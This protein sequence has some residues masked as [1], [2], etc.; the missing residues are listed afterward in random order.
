VVSS[1]PARASSSAGALPWGS[2][3]RPARCPNAPLTTRKSGQAW[4]KSIR[5]NRAK[6]S[7][8]GGGRGVTE[9]SSLEEALISS[10]AKPD[11]TKL[12]AALAGVGLDQ[13]L[14]DGALRDI[15]VVG[16]LAA[17]CRAV[18]VVRDHLFARTVIGFLVKLGAVP[19]DERERFLTSLTTEWKGGVW[20][21]PSSFC[22]TVLTTRTLARHA[23]DRREIEAT[24]Q[25][26]N[27]RSAGKY[28]SDKGSG[29]TR[30]AAGKGHAPRWPK[31]EHAVRDD[32]SRVAFHP[33]SR[34]NTRASSAV[35]GEAPS[36]P[37]ER[38][39][40]TTFRIARLLGLVVT[41]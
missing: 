19:R 3:S 21:R 40:S 7:T 20:E 41:Q 36:L 22:L 35:C 24:E 14:Q 18:G 13:L 31:I 28:R 17:F 23:R 5:G 34:M 1:S 30:P 6:V 9:E 26:R 38:I 39:T 8:L 16:T 2:V 15:P 25:A 12:A 11:L 10:I 29:L 4:T 32:G 27:L 33:L 37:A